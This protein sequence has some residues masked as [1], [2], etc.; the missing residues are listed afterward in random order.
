MEAR[1]KIRNRKYAS[2]IRDFAGLKYGKITPT[3]IDG[4]IDFGNKAF[5]FIETKYIDS[6]IPYGQKLAIER[7]VDAISKNGKYALGIIAE[8]NNTWNEEIDVANAIVLEYRWKGSWFKT[9]NMKTVRNL[10]D[11][12]LKK[13]LPYYI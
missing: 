7:V 2:Q 13:Y 6:E 9:K 12:L 1:G 5:I 3:D 11:I 4:L 10:I 8:H